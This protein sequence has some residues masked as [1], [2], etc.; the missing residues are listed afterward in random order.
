MLTSSNV[1]NNYGSP[2]PI[3]VTRGV[4]ASSRIAEKAA[5]DKEP[6]HQVSSHLPF[7]HF[8]SDLYKPTLIHL[9][10]CYFRHYSNKAEVCAYTAETLF[11]GFLLSMHI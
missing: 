11:P 6:F 1:E 5:T 10:V 9:E 3:Q 2:T 4:A 7:R 8:R